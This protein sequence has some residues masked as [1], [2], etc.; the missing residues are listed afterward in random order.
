MARPAPTRSLLFG[1]LLLAGVAGSGAAQTI[2]VRVGGEASSLVGVPL[3]MP[4]EVDLRNQPDVKL[5]SFSLVLRWNPAVLRLDRGE[6][7]TFGDIFANEDSLPLGVARLVGANPAGVGGNVVLGVAHFTPLVDAVDTL[8]LS[9]SELYAAGTF[10][11][12]LPS[13][14]WSDRAY[15]TARGRFGDLNSNQAFNGQDALL[16]LS[17]AVGIDISAQGLPLLGDVDG[18]GVTGARDALIILSAAVGLD[19]SPFRVQRIAAGPCGDARRP[20]FLV[21]PAQVTMDLGQAARLIAVARD[22]LGTGLVATDVSWTSSDPL[23]AE[24]G[25]TGVVTALASGTATITATRRGATRASATVAVSDRRTHWVDAFAFAADSDQIG[26]PELPFRTIAQALSYAQGGDTVMVRPGRY[27]EYAYVGKPVVIMG[28]T[29]G[30]RARPLIAATGAFSTGIL[31]ETG[32]RVE[33]HRLRLDTLY[34]AVHAR[35]VDTLLVRDVLFR[36]PQADA[37][38]GSLYVDSAEVV[39]VQR[40]EFFGSGVNDYYYYYDSGVWVDWARVV[41]LDSVLVSDYGYNGGVYLYTVDS[42]FVRGS[43]IRQNYGYGISCNYCYAGAGAGVAAV[44]TGNRFVQ[45][46]YGHVYFNG[47]RQ[48]RFD[49]NVLVG[50]GYDAISLYGDT[51]RTLVTLLGDSITTRQGGWINLSNFDALGVDSVVV[52]E[53]E[54]GYPDIRGGRIAA[55][56]NT[57]FLE[58]EGY[59]INISASPRDSSRLVLRNVQFHGDSAGSGSSAY[60][61]VAYQTSVDADGVAL[62]W[63]N[64]L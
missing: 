3:A 20:T 55:V 12:L 5:G 54:Y 52:R 43:V 41:S 26:A 16:V 45:N 32:G 6:N 58:L 38:Y 46:N 60:A 48:A 21:T 62:S 24:V 23:V 39:L 35:Y 18:D 34:Q 49:H 56:T 27:E 42:L 47:I 64:E 30:G 59:G 11:D 51:L 63:L 14:T 17:H 4:L 7:G 29:S 50:G 33:L 10:A 13:A 53:R 9:V 40:S 37:Y 8:R 28:D 22:S 15:C 61:V 25:A 1:V 44:L 31:V 57:K 36:S 2:T 19:V